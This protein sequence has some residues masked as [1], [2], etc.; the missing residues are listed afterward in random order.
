MSP[1]KPQRPEGEAFQRLVELVRR[2]RGEGGCPW[3]REQTPLTIKSYVL[4]EA[5]ELL[6]AVEGGEA[7][8]VREELGDVCFQ[9]VFLAELYREAGHFDLPAA[10][11]AARAKMI[12][13]HPHVFGEAVVSGAAEVIERW[14][15]LKT[16]EGKGLLNSVPRSLP[17]LLRAHRLGERAAR[18]GFDFPGA[19]AAAAKLEEELGEFRTAMA[20]GDR[21]RMQR[22]LGDLLFACVNVARLLKISAEDALRGSLEK[23]AERFRH[24]E[25]RL[26]KEGKTPSEASME[27][28]DK[29]WDELR[30]E[31]S[32][33]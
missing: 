13:R 18:V 9:I 14:H 7:A 21:E 33:R 25:E 6:E 2:L 11:E 32:D 15:E 12:R 16:E 20:A 10:L 28:M 23:F 22:E 29:I 31:R 19:G 5:Y 27:E 30:R 24:I 8:E 4:E 1:E 3:D 17:A 26:A